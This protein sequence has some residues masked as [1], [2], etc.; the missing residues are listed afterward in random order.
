MCDSTCVLIDDVYGLDQMGL[1]VSAWH[2]EKCGKKPF[3]RSL[4]VLDCSIT[5][6][7]V[8]PSCGGQGLFRSSRLRRFTHEP[9]GVKAVELRVRIRSFVCKECAKFFSE[10]T[11]QIS[12]N[13]GVGKLTHQGLLWAL[14][15]VVLD[16]MSISSAAHNLG[17]SP[18]P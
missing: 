7:V 11:K 16:S 12:I 17:A 18:I 13:D 5:V 15:A 3:Q 10:P 4:V 14:A 1:A 8:C 6:R 2:I 9:L